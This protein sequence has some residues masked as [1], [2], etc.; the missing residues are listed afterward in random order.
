MYNVNNKKTIRNLALKSFKA[1]KVRNIVAI[2]AIALTAFMFTTVATIGL[3]VVDSMELQTMRMIGTS[4]HAGYKN[5]SASEYE[6]LTNDAEIVDIGKRVIVGVAENE[7]LKKFSTEIGYADDFYAESGF[8]NPSIGRMPVSGNEIMTSSTIIEELGK[9]AEIGTNIELVFRANGETFKDTFE[10]VGLYEADPALPVHMAFVSEEYQ[11]KVAPAWQTPLASNKNLIYQTD[12][13]YAAGMVQA[14][15]NFA[16]SFDIES[17]LDELTERLGFD[18]NYVDP[19][20]NWGYSGAE[21]DFTSVLIVVLLVLIIMLGGYLIIYNVFLISVS[22]DIN[23]YG[24]LKTIGTTSKQLKKM[25][26]FQAMLLAIIGMSVGLVA[27][28]GVSFLIM[29][30]VTE[31]TSLSGVFIISAN[32]IIIALSVLFTLLTIWISLRK[33]YKLLT[34]IS[35]VEAVR[36][37]DVS[38][39]IK[40]KS[41]KSKKITPLS[42][43]VQNLKRT[44]GKTALVILSMTLSIVVLDVAYS[45]SNSF[46]LDTYLD[47]FAVTDFEVGHYSQYN[48]FSQHLETEAVTDDDIS[49]FEQLEGFEDIGNVYLSFGTHKF[50]DT[51]YKRALSYLDKNADRFHPIYSA[52]MIE[53]LKEQ[54]SM[55]QM[56]Y[57]VSPYLY[58]HLEIFDSKD[59]DLEKFD[60]GDYVLVSAFFNTGRDPYYLAGEKLT[61]TFANGNSKE[62]EVLAVG[63]LGGAIDSNYKIGDIYFALPESEYLEMMGNVKPLLV[64]FDVEEKHVENAENF[65][66]N[67][68]E[69]INSELAYTSKAV[70]VDEFESSQN[71]Y[72]IVGGGLSLILL[73]IGLFNFVN[74]MITSINSRNKEFAILQAIGMTGKNLKKMINFEGFLYAFFVTILVCT[75]GKVFSYGLTML[76]ANQIW[77]FTYDFSILPIIIS[78]P[79]IIV[80]AG[81]IPL[82]VYKAMNK[83]T[84]VERLRDIG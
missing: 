52:S 13:S 30:I 6:M 42:L 70:L 22:Q 10:V 8:S 63:Q 81:I 60:S 48:N 14:I 3:S 39:N 1:S 19:G 37:T 9:L 43:A 17:Q 57:G 2:L 18:T 77:F 34:K 21:I 51:S 64:A 41:K 16:S 40:T 56:V 78:I 73:F 54:Q 5:L 76:M 12:Y 35:P 44:R 72:L 68:T 45:I 33:P 29:P 7:E 15:F 23:F 4:S 61:L 31:T 26:S 75:I 69:N 49:A 58:D 50:S 28:Y 20:V 67:Y 79:I 36:F 80:L 82:V 71:M 53:L 32:P 38:T 74:M 27:G 25:I 11:E 66:K 55:T 84:I 59:S 24:L 65:I 62:Y 83:K 47:N 46:D